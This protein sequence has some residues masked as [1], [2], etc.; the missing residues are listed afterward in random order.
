MALAYY[1]IPIPAFVGIQE[2]GTR[3]YLERPNFSFKV[4]L[5]NTA[6]VEFRFQFLPRAGFWIYDL[7]DADRVPIVQ[8]LQV[9]VERDVLKQIVDTRRPPGKFFFFADGPEAPVTRSD[10]GARVKLYYVA[11]EP[12]V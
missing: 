10:L 7:N 4:P 12:D 11:D 2:G 5:P 8:G 1:N 3:Y 9:V 6:E